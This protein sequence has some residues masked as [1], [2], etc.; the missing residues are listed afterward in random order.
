[1]PDKKGISKQVSAG[2]IGAVRIHSH[3]EN[4]AA[5]QGAEFGKTESA[6]KLLCV[7]EFTAHGVVVAYC[8]KGEGA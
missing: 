5:R 4:K 8:D 6:F 1:M 2:G 3:L 7:H